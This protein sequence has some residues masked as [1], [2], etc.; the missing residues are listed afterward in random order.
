[1]G[2]SVLFESRTERRVFFFMLLLLFLCFFG[3]RC[4]LQEPKPS[5]QTDF[6]GV[7][8]F[9]SELD[10][11]QAFPDEERANL[12][13]FTMDYPRIQVPFEFTLWVLL[14]SFAKIGFHIYHKITIWIPESCLLITIGLIVGAIMHS[15]K[16]EPPAV[17]T[18]NVFFLYMLPLIVLDNGYFMP[19]RPFFENAGTVLWYA[20]VGTLWNSV[21]I[22]MSLFAICQFEVFGLQDINLQE[23]LLFACIIS[24]V[25]PV[26]ALNVFEDIGVN[27]QMYIVIFGEGLFNDAVTVVL[28][29]MFTFLAGLPVVESADVFLGTARFFLVAAGGILFGLLFGFVAAFTTRFTHNVRQ[30]EPLFVFMYSY[31]AYLL[32]ECF[33]ISSVMAIT[34]CAITMKYYVEE[35]VSQRSCTTIRHVV[36]MLATISETLIFFFLGVVTI[37][38]E[39][40]WNWAYILFTLLFT[41]IWRG[42]GILVLTQIINPFRTIPFHFKDQF[43][44]AYGGLRGAICFALV[45]TLPDDINRKNL[46]VTATV[47]VIIFTV[48]IQG[49]SIRPIVE[50]MNIRKTN[51]DLN[52]I[53]VE[54]HT[55]MMDHVLSGIED[56]CGQWSHYYWKDKFKKFNDRVLRRILIRDNRAESS[57]VALYKKL[58]LQNAI[59]LLDTPMG[60]LS[61]A[62]SIVSLHDERKD[63]TR[64]RKKFLTA[65]VRKMHDILSKNMYKIRQKTMAYTNKYNLPDDSLTR[66]ILI[67]RHASIR[68][69]V[70]AESFRELPSQN[71][72]RSQRYY[73]LQPGGDL[74]KAFP[75]RRRNHG[76]SGD[77][78]FSAQTPRSSSRSLV[79][80]RRLNTIMET[81]KAGEQLVSSAQLH[82][83]PPGVDG[84]DERGP[85]SLEGSSLDSVPADLSRL[86]DRVDGEEDPADS[87]P[88]GE[89][90]RPP[91]LPPPRGWV[92]EDQD[93]REQ[94]TGNPLLRHLSHGCFLITV[95][96]FSFLMPPQDVD[97]SSFKM[98]LILGYTVFLLIM[99]DL[100]PVTGN[101]IPLISECY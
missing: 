87:E 92:P 84:S 37:T 31:L 73:S 93:P 3:G 91:Q 98:T 2:T 64:P 16:E 36:K 59:G 96:L 61:A 43:G 42:I 41:L 15:V 62:P 46:F 72:P 12:P 99:N 24:T 20:V 65:D 53:N 78:D 22:G 10:E 7:K 71:I 57:I 74:E 34:T 54:V 83:P 6:P 27:E 68:R 94:E 48:F 28:Y 51:K 79:P 82:S 26:G 66:E 52:N 49:I 32:A 76:G 38:T 8:P 86:S 40:E 97:R 25:D 90:V 56:L 9:N 60:D 67:R 70:R 85:G 100:L 63:A 19:T 80:M 14:A 50:Y 77:V 47:A 33:A 88:A 29:N 5:A 11:P 1:M 55:R 39:H 89:P 101:T 75:L 45:F 18:S 81:G 95:D 17:L 23:N 35:N 21:G 58:E 30:I 4:E 44:L 13:V 69:S